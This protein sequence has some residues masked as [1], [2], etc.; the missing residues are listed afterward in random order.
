MSRYILMIAFLFVSPEMVW[1]L[2]DQKITLSLTGLEI[3]KGQVML[4]L[5]GSVATHEFVNPSTMKDVKQGS[6]FSL[7]N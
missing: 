2:D 7:K 4:S 1:K 5:M 3:I 6:F